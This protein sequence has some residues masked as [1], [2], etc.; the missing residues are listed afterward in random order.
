MK[1]IDQELMI[2]AIKWMA[3]QIPGGF[4]V[5]HAKEPM[6]IVYVNNACIRIFGCETFEEFKELTGN[7]FR[8]MVHPEDYDK[9]QASI[10]MQID[11]PN[12]KSLDY[13]EYRII[14]KDGK[15]RWVDDYGHFANLP[16]YGD[17]YYVFIGDITEKHIM[18]EES[19]KR[20][21]AYEGMIRHFNEF[22]DDALSVIRADITK[23]EII[24]VSGRDLYD[25]DYVG[26][27]FREG[28]RI[29]SESLVSL[30]DRI[31]FV[32]IFN[33]ENMLKRF[34]DGEGVASFTGYCIRRSGRQ[35]FVRFS[36]TITVDPFT[37]DIV[38]F[39]I[40]TEYNA[41]KVREVLN[42][43]VLARQYDMVAYIVEDHYGVVIGDAKNIKWGNIFPKKKDGN[44]SEY[45]N[46][47]VIPS[48]CE[49]VHDKE[50]LKE[51]LSIETIGKKL[52]ED[53]I[54]FVDMTCEDKGQYFFKRFTYYL[55]DRESHFYLLLKSDMTDVLHA[56]RERNETLANALEQAQQANIA[57]TSF[58]S[59][60]SHEIRTPM[61]AIIGLDNI[62]LSSPDLSEETRG[63]LEKINHSARHLLSLIND[64]LDM[65]RIESGSMSLHNEKFDL[66]EMIEQLKTLVM[67]Q[68]EDKGLHFECLTKGDFD[69]CYIGDEMKIKQILI[70]IL[71][72][73]VKFTDA[74]GSIEFKSEKVADFAGHT[75]VKFSIKDTGIGIDESFLPKIFDTFAQ[76]DS[77]RNTK[78]GS[79]G[80]GMAITRN[81]VE[82]MNGE[83]DVKSKKGEGSTFT[84]TVTLKDCENHF[85]LDASLPENLKALVIDDDPISLEDC[86]LQLENKGIYADTCDNGK[87]ALD[88]LKL[89]QTK[90]EL[91]DLVLVDWQM[92]DEDGLHLSHRIQ[93]LYGD[94]MKIF[95]MSA[96]NWDSIY[97]QA[98]RQGIAGF[99]SKPYEI[100]EMI[101]TFKEAFAKSEDRSAIEDLKGKHILLA[102]DIQINAQIMIQLLS[103]EGMEVKHAQNGKEALDM[104]TENEAGYF[105]AILMDVRMPVMD[106]LEASENIRA[107]KKEDAKKIPIIALTANAFDED[108]KRSL[109]AGMDAH[110]SKPV[111]PQHL[112][113]TLKALI[114]RKS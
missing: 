107:S 71:S 7:N 88:L 57:K 54:Y 41:E 89:K 6:D 1:N 40:E 62:A 103:M 109:Q 4:F 47:Q 56:E 36:S 43:R 31:R 85:S 21:S 42:Q 69:R 27:S 97:Q 9:I 68:C 78:Y 66:S 28:V 17:V 11:D 67:P 98:I 34:Y 29:R 5:Y 53:D 38:A 12:N 99:I 80:L 91:Y 101:D 44:Y 100:D 95:I 79:T 30:K 26:A 14:R 87:Q 70:N 94:Q 50:E 92:P 59:S 104:F 45:I 76:E 37:S 65:S 75:T 84:V 90:Q 112:Y 33:K 3:E 72:N 20:A 82:M 113:D 35:C 24:S 39:L 48:A 63:Y 49:S 77:S 96:Y 111:E 25:T 61:N 83:I 108:V 2:P 13:V 23:G 52:E 114:Y 58:L 105:D 81:L 8:G 19:Q 60:M 86:K 55:V 106:G 46:D 51:A 74:P 93:E 32:E 16:G 73:A 10:D 15:I 22:A 64:I 102:E 110:L 18:M